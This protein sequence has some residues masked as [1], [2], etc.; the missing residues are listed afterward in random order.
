MC[1]TYSYE[2]KCGHKFDEV[3]SIKE[4]ADYPITHCPKCDGECGKESRDYSNNSFTFIGTAV[5]S[6][7]YNPGLGCVVKDNYHKSEILKKK[8]LVEVGN[9]FNGG[10]KMQK[11]YE[12]KKRQEHE[13]K[14]A[15]KGDFFL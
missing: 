4:Y 10:E 5:Q 6:A 1:P 12:T 14:W 8:N 9:D 11:E 15:D 7:E 3:R 13:R 2:C